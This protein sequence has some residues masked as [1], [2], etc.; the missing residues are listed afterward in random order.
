M[1]GQKGDRT[2]Y[3]EI[4]QD[5]RNKKLAAQHAQIT[6][7]IEMLEQNIASKLLKGKTPE[8]IGPSP[9]PDIADHQVVT[10]A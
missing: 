2:H 5:S 10:V 1:M 6:N 7:K 3:I 8:T 9:Q 4:R